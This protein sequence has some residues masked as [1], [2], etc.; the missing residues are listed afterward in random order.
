MS[1]SDFFVLFF[2]MVA[3]MQ[4]M[5]LL[6]MVFLSERNLSDRAQRVLFYIPPSCFA[7][8]VANDL[9]SPGMFAAGIWEGAMPLVASAVVLAVAFKTRSMAWCIVV[10]VCVYVVLSAL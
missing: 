9:L 8:L 6:P 1:W 4:A 7:A 10:G 3:C 5:R 2:V